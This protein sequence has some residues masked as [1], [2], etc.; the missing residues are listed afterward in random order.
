MVL[1]P[2]SKNIAPKKPKNVIRHRK[3]SVCDVIYIAKTAPI[4]VHKNKMPKR[5]SLNE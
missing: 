3:I 5:V 1:S 4:M 2:P